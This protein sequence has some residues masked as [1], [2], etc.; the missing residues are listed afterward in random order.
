MNNMQDI[1]NPDKS[2]LLA[3]EIDIK[4]IFSVLW[5]K[6]I[7]ILI[8]TTVFAVISVF[9]ALS[10][11]NQYKATALLA[12]A[13]VES[14]DISGSL[15]QLGGLASLAG[16]NLNN[17]GGSETEMAKAIMISWNFIE[18]FINSNNLVAELAAVDGWNK[19]SNQLILNQEIYDLKNDIW[20]ADKPSSW[21]LYKSFSSMLSI[22]ET[23]S[24]FLL[25]SIEHYSP[26]V[27][28]KWLDLYIS[29]I[30]KHM[31]ELQVYKVNNNITYLQKQIATTSN[32]EMQNVFY[33]IIEEQI[34]NKMLAEA[35]PDYVFVS[36]S[37]SMVPEEKSQPKR[38]IICISLTLLGG[39]ISVLY[40]LFIHYR[41]KTS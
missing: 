38:A 9:Y 27:A 5:L 14:S 6:K 18:S 28:K 32:A 41:R 17:S 3:S 30:N 4:E 25:V 37:A 21:S 11:P 33:T 36:V 31:Q 1:N 40:V 10:I 39:I 22:Q 13:K 15:G 19:E 24:G 12:P 29:E 35:S 8:I 7:T 23:N 20:L 16:V 34:K 26:Y 2:N